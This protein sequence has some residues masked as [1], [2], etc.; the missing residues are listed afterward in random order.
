MIFLINYFVIY[1]LFIMCGIIGFIGYVEAYNYIYTGLK[2][3]QNRGIDSSG[4]SGINDNNQLVTVKYASY[5]NV[6][7]LDLL[8]N[9]KNKFNNINV[10]CGHNRW[11]TVGDKTDENAHPHEDYSKKFSLVHN[12]IIENYAEVKKDLIKNY[13]IE[14]KSQTDTE[15]IVNL[16]SILYD[17]HKNI[18][19]AMEEAF[20]ILEGTWGL[21]LISTL[22]PN[23]IYC[24]R[25]GSPLLIGF[26]ENY[27]M[28]ASEQSGF[29]NYVNTYICLNN[30]D[31]IVLEKKNNKVEFTKKHNY[32]IRSV[33][34]EKYSV[35]PDPFPH[36]TIKE[37]NEQYEA[38]MRAMG[39]GGRL[40][41]DTDVK[42]GGLH[43]S[44]DKFQ[45]IDN[46]ILLGCGTSYHAGLFTSHIFKS[47]SG[48]N[49]VQVFDGAE[50]NKSD[51]PKN[52]STGLIFI[53]QSGET[54][55]LHRCIEIGKELDLLMMGVVNVVDS[56][57]AR[58][59][60]CGVYLNA[61]REVAVASTKAFT[62]QVI[63]LTMVSIWFSQIRNINENKR[64]VLIN[65]LKRLP[66]DIQQIIEESS[67]TAQEVAKYLL[68]KKSMFLLGRGKAEASAKEASLKIKEI[69]YIHAEAYSSAALKHGPYS[70]LDYSTPVMI[71]MPN[72]EYLGRNKSVVDEIL[73]RNSDVIGISDINLDSRFKYKFKLPD[74]EPFKELLAVIPNQLIAYYL[75]LLK[76]NNPDF[77]RGLAKTVTTD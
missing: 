50:F 65:G 57:I 17:K 30:Q 29:C 54:K 45:K 72:N 49:S 55:D 24:A 70:L 48:F 75:S 71:I 32:T 47:I 73:G 46:I 69:G 66:Y 36:W 14:F 21:V 63:V 38:S 4:I 77:P 51:I 26:G 7:A 41:N 68:D 62:C 59:V 13:K 43:I 52:G 61:G 56:L 12:G 9:Y 8:S 22:T 5:D 6:I 76:G 27:M 15:V 35:T 18:E 2:I 28:V 42:L 67:N 37:I 11:R 34:N 60:N 31:I 3:L 10:M 16:I 33:V 64:T 20:T 74:N 40:L 19:L 53:S 23:K 25:H 58:E 44:K 39:M 1:I